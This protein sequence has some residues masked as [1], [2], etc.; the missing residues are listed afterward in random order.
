MKAHSSEVT[1]PGSLMRRHQDLI[2]C[3]LSLHRTYCSFIK[4]N[5]QNIKSAAKHEK[6]CN[7]PAQRCNECTNTSKKVLLLRNILH[8]K[9][10]DSKQI[11]AGAIRAVGARRHQPTTNL[12]LLSIRFRRRHRQFFSLG[13][14]VRPTNHKTPA[15]CTNTTTEAEFSENPHQLK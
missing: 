11:Q 3:L 4:N 10:K 7:I 6:R 13:N 5:K 15:S 8:E 2:F 9:H 14:N 1:S 12:C